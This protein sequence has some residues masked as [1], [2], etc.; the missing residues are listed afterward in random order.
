[1]TSLSFIKKTDGNE[2]TKT[3]WYQSF[4]V[5]KP[6]ATFFMIFDSVAVIDY[7]NYA[8]YEFED[9]QTVQN[10]TAIIERTVIPRYFLFKKKDLYGYYYNSLS[11]KIGKKLKM[12]SLLIKKGYYGH[13][14]YISPKMELI[15]SQKNKEGYGLIEKYKCKSKIDVTYPDTI[16]IYYGN[17]FKDVSFTL[18]KELDSAK[19]MKV[20][21]TRAIYNSQFI[22]G[23]PN[24][25][26]AY[27]YRFEL[28]KDTVSDLEKYKRFIEEKIKTNQ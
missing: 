7:R 10:D 2:I 9:I 8:L 1:M 25:F 11:D 13:T 22:N 5:F 17:K 6:D 15:N 23:Y 19:K 14:H 26:P 3:Y 27:E 28:K 24:K 18:S 16:I 21:K 4:P 20:Q 12:D